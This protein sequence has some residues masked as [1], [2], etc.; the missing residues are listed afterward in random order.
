VP[1]ARSGGSGGVEAI[2]A[3]LSENAATLRFY[4]TLYDIPGQRQSALASDD[5]RIMRENQRPSAAAGGRACAPEV[6][7]S[8]RAEPLRNA[9]PA[10]TSVGA[11][12]PLLSLPHCHLPPKPTPAMRPVSRAG[13]SAQRPYGPCHE[14]GEAHGRF[15]PSSCLET[16]RPSRRPADPC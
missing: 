14:S 12:F 1:A 3:G 9:F 7:R 13:R 5:A 6:A 10:L 8:S 2:S 4:D 11:G 15:A 16:H